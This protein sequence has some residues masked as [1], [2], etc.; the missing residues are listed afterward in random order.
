MP[1]S[2]QNFCYLQVVRRLEDY[3]SNVL[4]LLPTSLRRKLLFHLP[5]V[6]VCHLEKTCFVEGIDME[7]FWAELFERHVSRYGNNPGEGQPWYIDYGGRQLDEHPLMQQICHNRDTYLSIIA[8]VVLNNARPSGYFSVRNKKRLLLLYEDDDRCSSHGPQNA[9][10]DDIVNYLACSCAEVLLGPLEED[11]ACNTPISGDF[12]YKPLTYH[13]AYEA[14]KCKVKSQRCG[15]LLTPIR[16]DSQGDIQLPVSPPVYIEA[17]KARQLVPPRYQHYFPSG[18]HRLSDLDALRLLA[19]CGL[20]LRTLEIFS[21]AFDNIAWGELCDQQE[22]VLSR[23]LTSVESVK[24][25]DCDGHDQAPPPILAAIL[26]NERPALSVLDIVGLEVVRSFVPLLSEQLVSTTPRSAFQI[27][28]S[29]GLQTPFC[30]LTELKMEFIDHGFS[31]ILSY[32]H[33]YSDMN[34]LASIIEHQSRLQVLAVANLCSIW[35]PRLYTALQSFCQQPTFQSLTLS[36]QESS[37][38]LLS[39]EGTK[40]VLQSFLSSHC[41]SHQSL[42]FDG[43]VPADKKQYRRYYRP[44]SHGH[45]ESTGSN[46]SPEVAVCMPDCAQEHKTLTLRCASQL[47]TWLFRQKEVKL[48]SLTV[49]LRRQQY[50]EQ[51]KELYTLTERHPNF[52][53]QELTLPF[54]STSGHFYHQGDGNMSPIAAGLLKQANHS[55]L[56]ELHL[57]IHELNPALWTALFSFPQL[58]IISISSSEIPDSSLV[59]RMYKVWKEKSC[60]SLPKFTL[61][62]SSAKELSVSDTQKAKFEEMSVQY[63]IETLTL[64]SWL[65]S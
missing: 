34:D 10:P 22:I 12:V 6:D 16:Q 2:L 41:A 21:P 36:G 43:V 48:K 38:A 51:M 30:M 52:H 44:T 42:V 31:E 63:S 23:L 7:A 20:K 54:C 57:H 9:L 26:M 28:F 53:V 50:R 65:L 14:T 32:D 62:F 27:P 3:L 39:F 40:R 19:E 15:D 1:P 56:R 24:L 58:R 11:E 13:A 4:A 18:G 46:L 49:D 17:C 59:E 37:G 29:I 8:A 55:T 5:V 64:P 35:Y 33:S 61:H 25:Q 45:I 60:P 47:A